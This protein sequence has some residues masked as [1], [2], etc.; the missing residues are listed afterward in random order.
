[1][2]SGILFVQT[3]GERVPVISGVSMTG[4]YRRRVQRSI[5][6]RTAGGGGRRRSTTASSRS[7]RPSR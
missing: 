3:L 6:G 7:R 5:L 4:D 1:M 2:L